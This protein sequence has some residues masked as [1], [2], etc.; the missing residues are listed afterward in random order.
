MLKKYDTQN[1]TLSYIV[2][3]KASGSKVAQSRRQ[4]REFLK[5]PAAVSSS[6]K[7]QTSAVEQKK[8]RFRLSLWKYRPAET[9]HEGIL[10]PDTKP[11]R[12]V[13]CCQV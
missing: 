4:D 13:F 2:S 10:A 1:G 8:P 11:I 5:M 12:H 3:A 6:R 7:V 9:Y